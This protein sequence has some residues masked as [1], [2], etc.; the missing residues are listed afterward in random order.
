MTKDCEFTFRCSKAWDELEEFPFP[1]SFKIHDETLFSIKYCN[2]CAQNVYEIND[3][4][5]IEVAKANGLCV[6]LSE[7]FLN[8]SL[9]QF[10]LSRHETTG[11]RKPVVWTGKVKR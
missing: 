11:P 1:S 6:S 5:Q 8:P 10:D 3:E 2:V 7:S 9:K 4:S